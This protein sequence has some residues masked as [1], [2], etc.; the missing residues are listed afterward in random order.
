MFSKLAVRN[1]RRSMRD[2]GIYFL[3]IAFG[4]CLFYVFNSLETQ[5]FVL[6]R[7]SGEISER[8]EKQG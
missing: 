1:V 6:E 4:V 8:E 7:H 5:V 3:T 2:Y